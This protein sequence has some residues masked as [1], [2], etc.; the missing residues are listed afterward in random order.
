MFLGIISKS[1]S[2]AKYKLEIVCAV[3]AENPDG[4]IKVKFTGLRPGEKLYEELLIGD[5][6]IQ[7]EHP[8]IMQA[9]EERLAID[10]IEKNVKLISELR[11]K[12]EDISIKNI[13][14]KNINGYKPKD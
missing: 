12:Q 11:K 10:V 8:R 7:S 5:D 4:D 1:F 6:V 2:K 9:R 14:L 13:L 3:D